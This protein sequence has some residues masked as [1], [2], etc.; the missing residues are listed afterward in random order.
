MA[1]GNGDDDGA[2]AAVDDDGG[3]D[4]GN[5]RVLAIEMTMIMVFVMMGR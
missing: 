3:D 4:S 5:E 2:T 1:T